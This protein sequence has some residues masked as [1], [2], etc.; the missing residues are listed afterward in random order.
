MEDIPKLMRDCFHGNHPGKISSNGGH[1][2]L[3]TVPKHICIFVVGK[4]L[5]WFLFIEVLWVTPVRLKTK[6]LPNTFLISFTNCLHYLSGS[7][8][9]LKGKK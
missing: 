5:V 2:V 7:H 4:S 3:Y 1:S 6:A 9:G 8:H